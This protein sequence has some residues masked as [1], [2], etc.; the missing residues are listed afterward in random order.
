MAASNAQIVY[1]IDLLGR[2][3]VA[4]CDRRLAAGGAIVLP[5]ICIAQ[6]ALETGWGTAGLMTRANAFF[7]IKAGG[8]WTGKVYTADTWEVKGGVA[9]NTRANFRAY[10]S[11]ADSV[12]DYYDLITGASRYS[13]GLSYGTDRSK[14]LTPKQTITAIWA[15]GY[16]TDDEY[17]PKIMDHV[18]YRKLYEWDAL[19]TGTGSTAFPSSSAIFTIADLKQGKYVITDSGRSISHDETDLRTVALD[20]SKVITVSAETT[21]TVTGTSGFNLTPAILQGDV[22]S[23]GSAVANGGKFTAPAGSKIGFTLT[24][25][26]GGQLQLDDLNK[27]MEI[28]L[29]SE[30]LPTGDAT[31]P[32]A[33]AY[34]VHVK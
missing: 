24:I 15:G 17:V 12:R 31:R 5:S 32:A 30:G 33:L 1:F 14:W 10:D 7:G 22:A 21:Y 27:G 26:G 13:A 6:S 8:S 3:A 25:E 4:E 34:F 19:V 28:K 9:Y 11:L 16:A 2:L 29:Q 18:N 23:F 20:W